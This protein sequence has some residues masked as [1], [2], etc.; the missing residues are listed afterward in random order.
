MNYDC[1]IGACVKMNG[2]LKLIES[3]NKRGYNSYLSI[4]HHR[5]KL[6]RP[7]TQQPATLSLSQGTV[8]V[9]TCIR[10]HLHN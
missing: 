4:E 5:R 7:Q 9:H 2:I 1:L 10:L 6:T 3:S 8:E